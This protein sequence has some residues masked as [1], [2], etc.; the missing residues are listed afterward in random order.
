MAFV[1]SWDDG[2]QS[3]Y[4]TT[5]WGPSSVAAP[6]EKRESLVQTLNLGLLKMTQVQAGTA[7]QRAPR[8]YDLE[9]EVLDDSPRDVH[10][11]IEETWANGRA[12]T[13]SFHRGGE[14]VT[15]TGYRVT[16]YEDPEVKESGGL[17]GLKIT[18]QECRV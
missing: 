16:A 3:E 4:S 18:P 5:I 10:A 9:W 17:R 12:V 7:D 14:Q 13:C 2:V 8:R 15:C 11:M 1:F 6:Q